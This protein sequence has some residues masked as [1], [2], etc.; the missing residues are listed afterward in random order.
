MDQ[1]GPH[2]YFL[3]ILQKFPSDHIVFGQEIGSVPINDLNL[4]LLCRMDIE[5]I[6]DHHLLILP[7]VQRPLMRLAVGGNVST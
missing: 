7:V 6:E 5:F 3:R 1:L 4:R 2:L